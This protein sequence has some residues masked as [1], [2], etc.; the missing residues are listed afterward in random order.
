MKVTK[1]W[2]ARCTLSTEY[3]LSTTT[4]KTENLK[5]TAMIEEF[6]SVS[7]MINMSTWCVPSS[8][9]FLVRRKQEFVKAKRPILDCIVLI[10]IRWIC[11]E[12]EMAAALHAGSCYSGYT[13]GSYISLL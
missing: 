12:M 5:F 7:K 3:T 4:R 2:E 11:L 1:I 6:I 8:S 9:Y 13:L 10:G